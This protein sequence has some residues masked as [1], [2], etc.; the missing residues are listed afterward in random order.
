MAT[1]KEN[2]VKLLWAIPAYAAIVI[3]IHVWPSAWVALLGFHLALA[4]PLLPHLRTLPTHFFA[5]VS[6]VW[7]LPMACLGLLGGV[8]VWMLWPYIGI[9]EHYHANLA[10]LGMMTSDFSWPLFITYFSLVNPW[11]EEAFWRHLLTSPARGPALVDFLFAGFHILILV[12]FIGP[13]WWLV[14]LLILSITGW[15]W[16]IITQRTGSLLPAIIF[17]I[18]ADF[19]IVWVV[20]QKS[21]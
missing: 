9:A 18:F 16:R 8:A 3:G 7:F 15:V 11:I 21:L 12:L 6:P 10:S 5:P 19:S 4:I 1:N 13:F 20:Y 17:H 14:A 2:Y